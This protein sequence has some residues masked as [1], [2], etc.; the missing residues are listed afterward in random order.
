M[1]K[2]FDIEREY[3]E[4]VL[5][6]LDVRLKR[7][8]QRWQLAGQNPSD[9][10]RGLYISNADAVALSER[11]VGTHWGTGVDLPK[12]EAIIQEKAEEEAFERI[13][14]I[15]NDATKQGVKLRLK[16][17]EET[18]GLSAFEWWAFVVCLAPALD[19]RYERI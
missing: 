11:R 12:E 19:L 10:F 15:E 4:A 3:L 8:V 14:A 9:R 6:W 7:D 18:F 16:M 13:K 2:K 1:T 17:L 5:S